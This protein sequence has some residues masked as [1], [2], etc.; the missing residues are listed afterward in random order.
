MKLLCSVGVK[1][2]CET[3]R[4]FTFSPVIEASCGYEDF[5]SI[6]QLNFSVRVREIILFGDPVSINAVIASSESLIKNVCS[7][8]LRFFV[9]SCKRNMSLSF[10]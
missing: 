8:R 2:I 10:F 1:N 9:F 6:S 5:V 4:T 7:I 3:P